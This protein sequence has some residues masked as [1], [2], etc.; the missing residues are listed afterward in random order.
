M[1]LPI[2]KASCFFPLSLRERAGV[3]EATQHR[4]AGAPPATQHRPRLIAEHIPRKPA[5]ALA[6]SLTPTLSRRE[7]EK[8]A[9]PS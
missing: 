6:A 1:S 4:G 5:S 3:R 8:E 9:V 2:L 7:R